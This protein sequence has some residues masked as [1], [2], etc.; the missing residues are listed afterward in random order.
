MIDFKDRNVVVLGL[1]CSGLASAKLLNK[2]G[3]QVFISDKTDDV[4]QREYSCDLKKLSI[5]FEL[6][7]H[8]KTIIE[9]ADYL[10]ISPGV[11]YNC[12]AVEWAR[13]KNIEVIGEIELGYQHCPAQIIAITGTNGKTTVTTLIGK[14]LEKAGRDVF[15]L[16]NIGKPFSSCIDKIKDTDLISL[17]VSSFQLESIKEFRPKVSIIL[18]FTPDHLDRYKNLG[19]Y[20]KAKKQIFINQKKEDFLILNYADSRLRPLASETEAEVLYFGGGKSGFDESKFNPNQLAVLKVAEIFGIDLDNCLKVFEEFTG[21]EHRLEFISNING[22]DFINDSKATNIEA[23]IWALENSIKPTILIAGG[24][25]KGSDFAIISNILKNKVKLLVLF[26]ESKTKIEDALNGLIK[27]STAKDIYEAVN[28]AF[29]QAKKGDC[30]ILSPMCASFDMF[31]NYQE[32]GRIFKGIVNDLKSSC[33][34][35]R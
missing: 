23:T 8:T 20:L 25:D 26:G 31:S 17:E 9:S 11:S 10:V 12:E 1:G 30:I 7:K 18:N 13:K 27:I 22:I 21:I 5:D 24:R 14:I 2:L 29:K 4:K 35:A 6:G 32:R 3:A 34:A 33:R 19:E 15:V 28:L 16:G